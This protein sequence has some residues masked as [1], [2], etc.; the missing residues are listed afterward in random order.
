MRRLL[1][2]L[3]IALAILVAA[4]FALAWIPLVQARDAWR[5]GENTAAIEIAERWSQLYLWPQQYHQV[6]AAALLCAGNDAAARPHLAAIGRILIPVIAKNEVAEKLF[7]HERY[8]E[9]LAYDAASQ[10]RSDSDDVRL[11]RAAALVATNQVAAAEKV[12]IDRSKVPQGKF[13]ALQTAIA[14]RKSGVRLPLVLDRANG[15]ISAD[16]DYAPLVATIDAHANPNET[17]ETTLDPAVQKAALAALGKFRGALVAI[18]PQTNEILAVA[19]SGTDENLAFDHEYEPGSVVKVLTGLNAFTNGVDVQSMFPYDCRGFLDI[20]GRRFGDWMPQGHGELHSI[21][22]ALAVS[23]NVYFADLGLRIGR[24][25]LERYMA[26]AGFNGQINLGLFQVP[27]G[28]MEPVDVSD[29]FETGF[30]AIGLKHEQMNAIHLAMLASM[31]ANRGVLTT[32]RLFRER[33]SILGEVV[34]GPQQQGSTRIAPVAAAE[35]MIEA[36]QAVATESRGTGHRAPVGGISLAMKT[37][38]AGE[39]QEGLDA[40]ILAFAPVENPKIAF[41]VIA[42]G[43]GP[44]EFAGAKIAHDFLLALKPRL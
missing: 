38:T 13:A 43:A 42:Q 5:A 28:R 31:V 6:L 8:A 25:Q 10:E 7:A 40:I 26:S 37:G 9:F 32:P 16:P 1:V 4:L 20:D 30:L 23:C 44:A 11:D 15:S 29:N 17:I 18:D 12:P 34:A 35:R 19:N 2:P 21:D 3:L 33:R 14:V 24:D 39:R 22:D 27:L 41:G 36:M